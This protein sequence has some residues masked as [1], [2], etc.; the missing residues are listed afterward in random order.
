ARAGSD[1]WPAVEHD[2]EERRTGQRGHIG[3]DAPVAGTRI[4]R[5]DPHLLPGWT[6]VEHA[7][8]TT[9]RAAAIVIATPRGLPPHDFIGLVARSCQHGPADAQGERAGCRKLD[10]VAAATLA[11]ADAVVAGGN[12]DI[13]AHHRSN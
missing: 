12:T 3:H 11:A 6:A 2:V 9:G 8:T 10:M 4:E 7:D 13:D 5:D 1:I